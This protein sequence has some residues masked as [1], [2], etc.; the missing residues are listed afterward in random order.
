MP[1]RQTPGVGVRRIA[2]QTAPTLTRGGG[3]EIGAVSSIPF[4]AVRGNQA[5]RQ[6]Y[7]MM[8]DFGTVS[9]MFKFDKDSGL[10]ANL[11][12]Q[13]RLR[14]SRVPHIASYVLDNPDDYVFSAVTVS[15]DRSIV[16]EPV[17][18][19]DSQGRTGFIHVPTNSKIVVNDG[20]HR[21]AAIRHAC[22]QNPG[23]ESE[24]IAVVVFEDRGLKHSQQ[25]FADLNKHAVKPTKSLGL[26]YDH[27]DTFARF[28]VNMTRDIEVF[29][30]RTEEEKTNISN[31][32]TNFV[33][34][35][36]V[37]DATRHLLGMR[38]T[39]KSVSAENQK[40]AVEFWNSV[41]DNIPEWRLLADKKISAY[42]LRRE[43]VHAHTNILNAIGLAG[44]V[45]IRGQGWR[46]RLGGLRDI[47]WRKKAPGWQDN[48]VVDGKM[49][50]NR[51]AI[52]RAANKILEELGEP[53]QVGLDA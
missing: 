16:F 8:C 50:K 33:T 52:K 21:C 11:R 40:L 17:P 18:P 2:P 10:P 51:L 30:G 31:R 7:V 4:P 37:A 15:V 25:M 49:V 38:Q 46:D 29:A 20:Q 28:V 24:K 26:L 5:G 39:T 12:S 19:N 43:Y 13:R 53:G 45:L 23:I 22:E 9:T 6:F 27:R 1:T 35:N 47:D 44:N 42:E 14:S 48:V 3:S 32:S 36:G 41:S 34:L